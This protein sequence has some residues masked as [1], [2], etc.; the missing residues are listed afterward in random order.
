MV[1]RVL[2]IG[3]WVVDFLFVEKRYDEESILV[4]LYE[5]DASYSVMLRAKRIMESGR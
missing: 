2:K 4:F 5:F 1:H 3:R